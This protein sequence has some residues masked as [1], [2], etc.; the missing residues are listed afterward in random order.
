M[1]LLRRFGR[2]TTLEGM[3]PSY[4]QTGEDRIVKFVLDA[5]DVKE[6]RYLDIGA[7]HPQKLSNTFL[8]YQAGASGVL[9][10]PNPAFAELVR[11]TRPRDK[12]LNVGMAG[13]SGVDV[14][15]YVMASDTLSTFSKAEADRMVAECRQE[16][17][18]VRKLEVLSVADVLDTHFPTG[19]DYVSMDVEG[20]EL[21]L[22]EG[23][24]FEK[25]R[26]AVLCIET[27][28]YA[29]DGTGKKADDVISFLIDHRYTVH[30]D[31]HINTI[32]VERERWESLDDS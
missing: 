19:V 24:D 13:K 5:L 22:L 31:T 25:N 17:C 20:L 6:P 26:P 7:H 16:I 8:F 23:F 11:A 1:D 21:E 15:F 27:L 14:P 4:S 2:N 9:V 29:I 18:E 10:E 32:F 28:S 3:H 30:A 12:C